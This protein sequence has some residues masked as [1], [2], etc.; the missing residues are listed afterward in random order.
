MKIEIFEDEYQEWQIFIGKNKEENWQLIDDAS[1]TDIWFHV[2]EIP[3]CHVILKTDQDLR[4]ID[5]KVLKRCAL[6]CKMNSKAKTEKK[7]SIMYTQIQNVKKTKNIGEV[8]ANNYK[9]III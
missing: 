4:T 3:S 7:T 2:H 1:P 8:I 9:F 6:L 5:K